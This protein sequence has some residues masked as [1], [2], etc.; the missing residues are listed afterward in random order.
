[1]ISH[2]NVVFSVMQSFITGGL[3]SA[4]APVSSSLDPM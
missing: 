3:N 4:V 1:M 2:R